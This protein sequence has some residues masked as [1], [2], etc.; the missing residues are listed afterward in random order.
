MP[1]RTRSLGSKRSHIS[2]ETAY[3]NFWHNSLVNE[4]E[5]DLFEN[6]NVIK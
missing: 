1:I 5:V 4:E 3:P 6:L 2:F